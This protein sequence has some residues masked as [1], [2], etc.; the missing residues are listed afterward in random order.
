MRA[1]RPR[2]VAPAVRW[3][4]PAVRRLAAT[5]A[6]AVALGGISSAPGARAAVAPHDTVTESPPAPPILHGRPPAPAPAPPA[7]AAERARQQFV[8]GL[9]YERQ[10]LGA[11][12][13]VSFSN[14]LKLDPEL[15]DANYHIGMLFVRVGQYRAA[16]QAFAAELA[17]H[18]DHLDAARELGLSHA[19][20][21]RT[22][23]AIVELERVSRQRPRD[24]ETWRALGFAYAQAGRAADAERALRRAI[25]LP[26][27]TSG[28]HRDLGVLL[29]ESGRVAEARAE[30]QRALEIDPR[31]ASV[32]MDL[33]NLERR[34]GHDAVA[35][36]AYRSAERMD[37]SLVDAHRAEIRLLLDTNREREAGDAYRRWLA[38]VPGDIDVRSEA[39]HLWS[40]LGRRDVALEVARDGVRADP[41]SSRARILLGMAL[42]AAGRT[43]EA[44]RELNVAEAGRDSSARVRARALIEGMRAGAPDSLRAFFAAESLAHAT[45]PPPPLHR[46]RPRP[47]AAAEQKDEP[48]GEP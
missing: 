30:Y 16:E 45:T 31:D 40:A 46:G 36:D 4:T 26:P 12:A 14:A 22:A 1:P 15:R 35:L 8:Q 17:R 42:D 5:V 41:A 48:R 29:A 32:W 25:A 43:R 10:G 21:G 33:G 24:G 34:E 20:L 2:P 11:P 18:P 37:S 27:E 9:A 38:A 23:R 6:L 44:V 3:P 19:R 7:S 28:E 39:V 47:G 13:I